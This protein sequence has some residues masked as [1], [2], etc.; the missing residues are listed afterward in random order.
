VSQ[1]IYADIEAFFLRFFLIAFTSMTLLDH[2][3]SNAYVQE[4]RQPARF[5]YHTVNDYDIL[6]SYTDAFNK[7]LVAT[8][9][10]S[11]GMPAVHV[12]VKGGMVVI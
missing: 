3:H 2:F 6:D 11:G 9:V 4:F 1:S 7:S 5:N 10:G 12:N 8:Y